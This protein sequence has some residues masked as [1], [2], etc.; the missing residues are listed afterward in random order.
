MQ[1]EHT[2]T[3]IDSMGVGFLLRNLLLNLHKFTDVYTY[4]VYIS[5]WHLIE[6]YTEHR[7][8]M[9]IENLLFFLCFVLFIEKISAEDR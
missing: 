5:Y 9:Q 2:S 6:A 7:K 4:N 8:I 1:T 3:N